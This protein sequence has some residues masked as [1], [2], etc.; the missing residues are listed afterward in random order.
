MVLPPALIVG[1]TH[2]CVLWQ[3]L[4]APSQGLTT[5]TACL[6]HHGA[7]LTQLSRG[8]KLTLFWNN[9][10]LTGKLQCRETPH[11][12]SLQ[13]DPPFAQPSIIYARRTHPLFD[14][15]LFH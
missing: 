10:N 7:Y 3:G 4:Q 8:K 13:Y 14:K 11:T 5:P 1:L 9:F 12:P 15:I 6:R 2:D